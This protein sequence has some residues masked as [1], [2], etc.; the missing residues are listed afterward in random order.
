M[1]S[2]CSIGLS[3]NDQEQSSS[4]RKLQL[5]WMWLKLEG[6]AIKIF[7]CHVEPA[8]SKW[9]QIQ[10]IG[11]PINRWATVI[12]YHTL[13]VGFGF[14]QLEN[15]WRNGWRPMVAIGNQSRRHL[16]DCQWQWWQRQLWQR[17]YKL[18]IGNAKTG[19]SCGRIRV[20]KVTKAAAAFL[21]TC[22]T[23]HPQQQLEPGRPRPGSKSKS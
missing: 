4:H 15:E 20:D 6:Y 16:T 10:I 1:F 22:L 23:F 13:L 7:M 14:F 2:H 19:T 5:K 21:A 3:E 18:S 9:W 11:N 8:I 12:V 17:H